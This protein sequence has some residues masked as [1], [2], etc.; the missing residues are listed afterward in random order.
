VQIPVIVFCVMTPCILVGEYPRS[1]LRAEGGGNVILR[2]VILAC[3]D[4]LHADTVNKI[5]IGTFAGLK[6]R[7]T[8]YGSL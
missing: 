6:N 2:E 4:S 3:Q 5:K 1:I 7:H 8:S